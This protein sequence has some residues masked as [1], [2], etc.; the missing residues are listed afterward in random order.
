VIASALSGIG[1]VQLQQ[2]D[3]DAARISY[4]NALR[5]RRELGENQSAGESEVALAKLRI[6]EGHPADAE[7]QARRCKMQF[8]LDR[9]VDDELSAGLVIVDSLIAETKMPDAVAE[10]SALD[11]IASETQNHVLQLRYQLQN[12]RLALEAGDRQTARRRLLATARQARSE[13]YVDIG[14]EALRLQARTAF[15]LPG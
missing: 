15:G 11:P 7:A 8:H 10:M 14:R 12:A 13:G 1:D 2:A 9:Q 4:E 3:L 5:L 6:Q